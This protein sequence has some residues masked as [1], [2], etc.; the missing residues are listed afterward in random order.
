[1]HWFVM[2]CTKIEL[3]IEIQRNYYSKLSYY[4]IIK[5]KKEA[6]KVFPHST[7]FEVPRP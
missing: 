1:M 2:T 5:N 3:I 7:N 6:I 4:R